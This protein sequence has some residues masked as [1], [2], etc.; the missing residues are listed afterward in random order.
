MKISVK[1]IEENATKC[2][3]EMLSKYANQQEK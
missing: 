2:C 3:D 1:F